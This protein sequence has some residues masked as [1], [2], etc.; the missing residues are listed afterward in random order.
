[1]PDRVTTTVRYRPDDEGFATVSVGI[2]ERPRAP[3]NVVDW[4]T[5]GVQAALERQV[6]VAIPGNTGQGELWEAAWRW[7]DGRPRI[8]AS[9]S[10]PRAGRL[11]GIWRVDG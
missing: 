6:G 3:R 2:V 5:F 7:W 4:A 11:G 8:A 10:A 1:L 9:F